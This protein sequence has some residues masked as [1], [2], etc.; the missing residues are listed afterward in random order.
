MFNIVIS[1]AIKNINQN[2]MQFHDFL[3]TKYPYLKFNL[4]KTSNL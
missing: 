4:I 3:L 1:S 2:L